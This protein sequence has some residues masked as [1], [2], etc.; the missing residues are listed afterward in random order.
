[1]AAICLTNFAFALVK[2]I[3]NRELLLFL[4][5]FGGQLLCPSIL[6]FDEFSGSLCVFTFFEADCFAD[7][8]WLLAR[9]IYLLKFSQV[10][11]VY[12]RVR[13]VRVKSLFSFDERFTRVAI[14]AYGHLGIFFDHH[15]TFI[16]RFYV[17]IDL[18][19]FLLLQLAGSDGF[20]LTHDHGCR[21]NVA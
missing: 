7:T 3:L 15:E 4:F 17:K 19:L 11:V 18:F 13:V 16:E 10:Q 9:K 6:N 14:Q 21:Y 12:L 20:L 8:Y 5:S 1:M 2:H